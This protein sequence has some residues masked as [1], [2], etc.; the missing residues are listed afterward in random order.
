LGP[1][2]LKRGVADRQGDSRSFD[3]EFALNFT[4]H[5]SD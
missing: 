2:V 1:S 5:S 3:T 4:F